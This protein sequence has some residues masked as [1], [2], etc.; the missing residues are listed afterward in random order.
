MP[1]EESSVWAG[2]ERGTVYND[3]PNVY[4]PTPLQGICRRPRTYRI[5]IY[6]TSHTRLVHTLQCQV[7]IISHISAR[8]IIVDCKQMSYL[9][10]RAI[11]RPTI[12]IRIA[13]FRISTTA[14]TLNQVGQVTKRFIWVLSLLYLQHIA[15]WGTVTT[16]RPKL[17]LCQIY[18]QDKAKQDPVSIYLFIY[19]VP[20]SDGDKRNNVT[21]TVA[22]SSKYL[23][24]CSLGAGTD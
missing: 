24:F 5:Y 19:T 6:S 11:F 20:P 18:C 21:I 12:H 22:S 13:T 7:Y 3:V 9:R 15:V 16:E 1:G 10:S 8:I 2:C 14:G 23:G 4:S 17:I